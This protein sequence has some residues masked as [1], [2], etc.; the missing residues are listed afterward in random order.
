[1]Q[2]NFNKQRHI[3]GATANPAVEETYTLA[4]L[5]LI[6]P[7]EIMPAGES[8]WTINSRMY[9]RN[10]GE[11]RVAN[12]TRKG[13]AYLST[14]VG[15][16]LNVVNTATPTGPAAFGHL[17]D[18]TIRTLAQ[19]FTPNVTGPLTRLD[20]E[21]NKDV[22]SGGHVMVEVRSDNSGLPSTTVIGQGAILGNNLTTSM[23]FYPAYF[24]D[25]P[26]LT[27]GTQYWI[28]WYVQ[29][30]GN[31]TYYGNL[32]AGAGARTTLDGI[33]WTTVAN[34]FRYK[35]YLSTT[36][37]V[38]GYHLRYPSVASNNRILIAH[39]DK[40]ISIPKATGVPTTIDSGLDD[41]GLPVR[42]L[43]VDDNTYWV[44][45]VGAVR[46]WDG[47][48]VTNFSLPSGPPTVSN[49]LF[50]KQRFFVLSANNRVDF[51]DIYVP[52]VAPTW[53]SVNFF[54]IGSPKSADHVMGWRIFQDKLVVFTHETKWIII[55]SDISTFTYKQAVGTKGAVSQEAI[56]ADRNAIY[57]I[58]DDWQLYAFNG[59]TDVLLSA[60]VQ[61]EL[62]TITD[63]SRVRVHVYRNQ[64]R[65]YYPKS[66]STTNNRMLLWDLELKQWFLDTDHPVTGSVELFLDNNELIEF[67]SLV[68]QVMYGESQGSDLGKKID[69]KYWTAY[70]TYAYRRRNGQTFGGGSAKKRIKRLRPVVKIASTDFNML[71]GTDH[72]FKNQPDMRTYSVASGGAKYGSGVA[73]ASGVVYGGAKQIANRSGVSGR[74]NYV[75]YRF[76]RKG[77]E[78]P[79]ELYGYISIYKI[80]K[81]K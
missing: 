55:G 20:L 15:E 51:S 57:F 7:D 70:K 68:G 29:D 79:V 50:W 17:A 16:T 52:G 18:G 74:A 64:V 69:Y 76:E 71:A 37:G 48:T 78:T 63:P 30:N 10:D 43:Q 67:S 53:P 24:I 46:Q 9:A 40:V 77:V 14:P 81:Q 36:G 23:A 28:V 19:S 72:D 80:G 38:R 1:M 62:Q 2:S 58:G 33:S 39:R 34:A 26:T 73:Y 44:N 8:P 47:V 60:K 27:S 31:G 4:G 66:P 21:L 56:D 75:Q 54:Y 22:G 12:R 41:S 3:P 35:T 65:V 13:A 11:S 45:G 42:F 49:I 61:P 32:T 59:V 5:N 6:T 25:A